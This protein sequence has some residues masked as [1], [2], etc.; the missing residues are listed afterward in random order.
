MSYCNNFGNYDSTRTVCEMC[1]VTRSCNREK[2]RRFRE[3]RKVKVKVQKNTD[4]R[5]LRMKLMHQ[6]MFLT[7]PAS[8]KRIHDETR[9]W[10][11]KIGV[12][13]LRTYLNQLKDMGYMVLLKRG[14]GHYW[15]P[16]SNYRGLY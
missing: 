7:E 12:D 5:K 13:R 16:I 14:N 10:K 2:L 15:I 8:T 3:S 11:D 6:L 1:K 9:N 4:D